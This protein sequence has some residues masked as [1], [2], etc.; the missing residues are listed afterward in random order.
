MKIEFCIEAESAAVAAEKYGVDRIELCSDLKQDG[1]TPSKELILACR[2]A[3]SGEI[4][5]MIRP[6]GGDFH[7]SD[8]EI[9]QML[10][11]IKLAA[12]CGVNG[13][14][15]GI[16][17]EEAGIDIEKNS[18]LIKAAQEL[19]LQATFHRAFDV[20]L[21]PLRTLE[22][23]IEMGFK[24]VLTSGQQTTAPEGLLLIKNLC[25][26]ANGRIEIMAGSGVGPQ[27]INQLTDIG[28]DAVHF[29]V[30]DKSKTITDSDYIDFSKIEGVLE[31]VRGSLSV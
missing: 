22:E 27:T 10:D 29:S 8:A 31:Q 23:L 24:R 11:D 5:M 26:Q 15:F 21:A 1:L 18:L 16:L 2:K 19:G 9:S 14:V 13:V 12:E 3:F 17:D 20:C 6:R 30:H 4:H 7:Y 25:E 28:L